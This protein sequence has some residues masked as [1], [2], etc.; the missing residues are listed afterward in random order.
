MDATNVASIIVAAVAALAAWASARA[1]SKASTVRTT[2]DNRTEMEK[3]AYSRAR[4]FDLETIA[5][6]DKELTELRARVQ[7][8]EL[9][10]AQLRGST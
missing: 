2:S 3:D 5:R 1:S 9:V 7:E 8:L 4:A 6:Q 10:V